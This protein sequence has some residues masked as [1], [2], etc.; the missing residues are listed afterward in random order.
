MQKIL[1][2]SIGFIA[3]RLGTAATAA[4]VSVGVV[5]GSAETVGAGIAAA[6]LI[7]GEMYFHRKARQ[8]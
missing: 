5:Q 8:Q 6:I 1:K 3:S 2:E 4:L 7:A